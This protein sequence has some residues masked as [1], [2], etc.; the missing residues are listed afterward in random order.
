[1]NKKLLILV[2]VI[3]VALPVI[4]GCTLRVAGNARSAPAIPH[5]VDDVRFNN[6]LVCHASDMW[7]TEDKAE[8]H[9]YEG[10]TNKDCSSGETCHARP[11]GSY[12]TP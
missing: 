2:A 1:M 9:V 11:D 7:R 5:A 6:C 8:D 3:L 10:Y 4:S 12:S